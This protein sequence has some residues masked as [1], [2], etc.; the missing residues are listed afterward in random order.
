MKKNNLLYIVLGAVA[1]YYLYKNIKKKGGL[2]GSMNLSSAV[3][4]LAADQAKNINFVPDMSTMA[5]DY[6]NALKKC[7]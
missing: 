7:K 2:P 4:K 5:D 3:N 1:V 6:S